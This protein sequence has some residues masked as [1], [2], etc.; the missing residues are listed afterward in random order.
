MDF[1][2]GKFYFMYASNAKTPQ[3]DSND[4]KDLKD[5]T[6]KNRM[7]VLLL[8]SYFSKNDEI[9]TRFKYFSFTIPNRFM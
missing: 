4:S 7:N 9:C 1:I 3:R 6:E 5:F 2:D 8:Q